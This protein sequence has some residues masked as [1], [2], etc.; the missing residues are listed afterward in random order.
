M[1][2]NF[3]GYNWCKP[4]LFVICY[5]HFPCYIRDIL[6]QTSIHFLLKTFNDFGSAL[7]PPHIGGS[8]FFSLAGCKHIRQLGAWICQ[9][10]I[11]I[12]MVWVRFISTWPG[13]KY[14][15]TQL[16]HHIVMVLLSSKSDQR[17]V[18]TLIN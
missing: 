5:F 11:V 16:S 9:C 13:S 10:F 14:F 3:F 4:N 8:Y 7:V 18:L 15:N 12:G 6:G 2:N 1:T 17:W